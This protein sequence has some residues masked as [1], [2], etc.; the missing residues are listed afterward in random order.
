[1]DHDTG[2]EPRRYINKRGIYSQVFSMKFEK[3]RGC[4]EANANQAE[5]PV[6]NPP[7]MPQITPQP[8]QRDHVMERITGMT[9]EPAKTPT[10]KYHSL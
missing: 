1:M 4:C 2:F 9:A 6:K 3:P 10:L 8:V 5:I 7:T